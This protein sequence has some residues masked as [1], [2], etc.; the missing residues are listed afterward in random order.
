[1]PPFIVAEGHRHWVGEILP[2]KLVP[3]KNLL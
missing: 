3:R 1:L 2:G